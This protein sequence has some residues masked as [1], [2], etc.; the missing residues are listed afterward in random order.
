MLHVLP[1]RRPGIRERLHRG[2]ASPCELGEITIASSVVSAPRVLIV[3]LRRLEGEMIPSAALE[4][5]AVAASSKTSKLR[6][7]LLASRQAPASAGL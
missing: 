5:A 6:Y 4:P 2:L 1:G 7:S 3:A